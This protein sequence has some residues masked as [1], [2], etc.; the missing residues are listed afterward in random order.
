VQLQIAA[1][2]IFGLETEIIAGDR[3]HAQ[4]R[5]VEFDGLGH[6]SGADREVIEASYFHHASPKEVPH[7]N[8]NGRT[9]PALVY[10]LITSYSRRPT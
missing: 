6:I 7:C 5:L 10:R 9:D 3:L 8:E 1:A 2:E 4:H